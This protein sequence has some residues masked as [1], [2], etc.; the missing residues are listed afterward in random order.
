MSFEWPSLLWTLLLVPLA[1]VAYVLTERRRARYAVKFTNLDL[2]A[3]LV[4]QSPGWRRHVP[5]VLYL[6][7]LSALL[8]GMARPRATVPLPS[9]QSTVI[10]LLDVSG[11]MDAVD[12]QP[13]R[14]AAAQAAANA[15]L[16]QV[17][18]SLRVG[19]VSFSDRPQ[20]LARPTSD[21]TA[22]RDALAS[23]RAAGGTAIGEAIEASLEPGRAAPS[24]RA[25]AAQDDAPR[26][27]LLLSDGANTAGAIQ[28]QDAA[29]HA[30]R[31]GVPIY[32]IALGTPEGVIETREVGGAV[33]RVAVPPD[34]PTLQQIAEITGGQFFSAPTA[35]DLTAVYRSLGSRVGF[36][37]EQQ[38]VTVLFA[39]G[40]AIFM[41]VAAALSVAWFNRFP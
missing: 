2:L 33:G 12:V 28:P 30:L 39:A 9:D 38:E 6:V 10:L 20:V 5:T 8:M 3:N 14:L 1:V 21:R 17:P 15:F 23:L 36:R 25:P 29:G 40:A 19:V 34:E 27:L 35:E 41:A 37:P 11:S 18:P 31:L 22:V 26:V 16:E 13:T 7:A 24:G 32:T 4:Q